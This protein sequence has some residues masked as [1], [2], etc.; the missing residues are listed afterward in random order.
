[1]ST[2]MAASMVGMVR[3]ASPMGGTLGGLRLV[4]KSSSSFG[5]WDFERPCLTIRSFV[6]SFF[7]FFSNLASYLWNFFLF[8]TSAIS[9]FHLGL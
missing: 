6:S 3:R 4:W 7:C 9:S 8:S 2:L 1:M 5:F